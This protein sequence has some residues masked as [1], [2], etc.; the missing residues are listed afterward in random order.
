MVW[1]SFHVQV[2]YGGGC[3]IVRRSEDCSSAMAWLG[4]ELGLVLRFRVRI[5]VRVKVR[6]S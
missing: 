6:V 1:V 4:S 5:M 2:G 3:S